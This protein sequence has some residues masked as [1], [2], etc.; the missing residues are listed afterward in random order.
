MPLLLF[1]FGMFSVTA[2]AQ[3]DTTKI[4][5]PSGKVQAIIPTYNKAPEGTVTYF[6]EDG[7]IKEQREYVS[8]KIEGTI[9]RYRQNGTLAEIITIENGK[10]EGPVSRFDEKGNFIDEQLYSG[11]LLQ[12]PAQ[13]DTSEQ[14]AAVNVAADN[15]LPVAPPEEKKPVKIDTAPLQPQAVDQTKPSAS[16]PF[17]IN[18]KDTLTLDMVHPDTLLLSHFDQVPGPAQGMDYFKQKLVYPA[19]AKNKQIQGTVVIKA[20]V[21]EYGEIRSVDIVKGIGYGCDESAS[22]AVN[23]TKFKPAIYKGTALPVYVLWPV[24]YFLPTQP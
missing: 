20:L 6:F 15:Q 3:Y 2:F 8:G 5:Y 23:Y 18:T 21:D 17:V 11:G 7:K 12:P 19:Y 16:Q 1:M 13:P 24:D 10:R 9:K 4:Y 22:I 14:E